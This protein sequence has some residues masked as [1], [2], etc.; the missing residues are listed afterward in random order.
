[1]W[2]FL[3]PVS[4]KKTN[5]H[6]LHNSQTIELIHLRVCLTTTQNASRRLSWFKNIQRLLIFAH[7]IDRRDSHLPQR[8]VWSVC[9]FKPITRLSVGLLTYVQPFVAVFR[10]NNLRSRDL[11]MNLL[12]GQRATRSEINHVMSRFLPH[13]R[14]DEAGGKRGRQAAVLSLLCPW[15]PG[16][17]APAVCT[18]PPHL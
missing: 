17:A 5:I 16:S 15:S 14:A 1:M 7:R 18:R 3:L 6:R 9:L 10:N 4:R 12:M 8:T 13:R 2:P 11:Q